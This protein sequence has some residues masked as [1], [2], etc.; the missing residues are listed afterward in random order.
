MNTTFA[1]TNHVPTFL[2]MNITNIYYPI[3]TYSNKNIEFFYNNNLITSYDHL[4][5]NI[6]F[7]SIY[8]SSLF[9]T[10]F[11]LDNAPKVGRKIIPPNSED[12]ITGESINNG[13]ILVNFK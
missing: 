11:N 7:S 2:P 10:N 3:T 9:I 4:Y 6:N 12:V 13:D 1:L 8:L 5:P